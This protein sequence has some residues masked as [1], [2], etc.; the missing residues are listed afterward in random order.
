M[1]SPGQPRPASRSGRG[2]LGALPG[3]SRSARRALALAGGLAV[4]NAAVLVVQAWALAAVLTSY[5]SRTLAVL[6]GAVVARSLLGWATQ[7]VSTRAAAGAK[8]ELRA[9]TLDRAL[10]LGPEWVA[11]RG[12]GELTSLATRGLDA[13]DAYFGVYLP[14][15]VTAAVAPLAVGASIL[16][17]DWPSA[18]V[19]ALTVPLIPLFAVVIGRYTEDRVGPAAAA[20]E[21]LSGNLLELVRALPVLTAFRRASAQAEAVRKVS[22]AHRRGTLGVLRVAFMSA[23][24]LE[25]VATLS[26]A[27]VAVVIGVRLVAGDLTLAVGLFVLIVVPECYLPLRAAG[28]AHHASEDGLEAIRRVAEIPEV[29]AGGGRAVSGFSELR[30]DG[31]RVRRRDGYAPDGLSLVVRPGEIVRLDSASGT[32]KS[33][34]FAALL[35]FVPFEGAITVD[36]TPLADIDMSIWRQ[37]VTWVPQRPEFAESLVA[38]EVDDVDLAADLGIVHLVDRRIVELSAGERQRVALLRALSRPGTRLLLLDEPTAHLDP[39]TAA[40]VMA[41]IERAAD[42]GIAVIMATHRAVTAAEAAPAAQPPVDVADEVAAGSGPLRG[43]INRRMLGGAALGSA[44]LVSGVLLAA[45]SAWLIAKAAQQPPILTLSIAVVGVRAFGLARAA[46]RYTE[47]LAVHDAVFRTATDLRVRLWDALV[48]IGPARALGL[49]SGEGLRRFVDDVDT[50]RDLAPRVLVP[51]L[52]ALGAC[53]AAIAV[54][55][56]ILP[57]AGLALAIAVVLAGLGAPLVSLVAERRATAALSEGRRT[58]AAGVLTLFTCAPDLI[59]FGRHTQHRAALASADAAL[60]ARAK[61]Q[62]FGAGAGQALI[63]LLLGAA[64]VASTYLAVGID[65]VLIPIVALVPLALAEVLAI[66]PPA[67]THLPALRAAYARISALEAAP[68]APAEQWNSGEGVH[69]ENVTARWPGASRPVLNGFDLR[70]AP[71]THAAVVGPSGAGKSTLAA[72]LLGFINPETGSLTRPPTVAWCPQ[73]PMLVSTSV[74]ENLKLAAPHAT[75]AELEAA[76]A[77]A[78]LPGFDLDATATITSG[79][80][81]Q[82]IALARALLAEADL[83]VLDEPTAHLDVPTADRVL[84]TLHE[85]LAGKTVIHITHRPAEAERAD[86]VVDMGVVDRRALVGA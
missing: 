68:A 51:P 57:T 41:A 83:I 86:V 84:A 71:G 42:Q 25:L 45:L 28:A 13:L 4:V 44:A 20:T 14:A 30:I 64:T 85:A 56:A 67:V 66:L 73:D 36:G 15:L 16:F 60:V 35:G 38:A 5:S 23:F 59:A 80:E 43:L 6:A 3:L 65:P 81:A 19:V 72:L 9:L 49:R 17:V 10:A 48:R 69:L 18:V 29:A 8:E 24:A 26:V 62:A 55:T 1:T 40:T 54:Q 7:V 47:R 52:V 61:R 79:G 76:L 32:G 22:D 11:K 82:R 74:R 50:V 2:P 39:A 46:L 33:T 27:L 75:D 31:L 37:I 58:V 12:V 70:L 77:Q 34:A 63:T 78:G 21:R 53:V